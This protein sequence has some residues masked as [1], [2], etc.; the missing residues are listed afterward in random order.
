MKPYLIV[1]FLIILYFPLLSQNFPNK[2]KYKLPK[3]LTEV[4]GLYRAAPD[5]LWWHN[6][7]GHPAELFLT[8]SR[9]ALLWKTPVPDALNR[10][11]EDLTVPTTRAIST[12][13]TSATTSTAAATLPSISSTPLPAASIPSVFN[14]R[15]NIL[16]LRNQ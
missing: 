1:G 9:G 14:I 6:D 3:E 15:T 7:G 4:S 10:D 12:S 13:A 11:W 16:S 8:D 5:S 2:K